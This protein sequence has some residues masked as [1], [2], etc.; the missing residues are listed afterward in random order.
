MNMLD[1]HP[2]LPRL[3]LQPLHCFELLAEE[4]HQAVLTF[5]FS[6]RVQTPRNLRATVI[7]LQPSCEPIC[8]ALSP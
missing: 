7:R 3:A 1:G 8:T 2:L 4:S 5:D 6:S